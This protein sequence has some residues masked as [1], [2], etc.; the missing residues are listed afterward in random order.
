MRPRTGVRAAAVAVATALALVACGGDDGGED[1]SDREAAETTTTAVV[2]PLDILV[3]NDDGVDAEGIDVLVEALDAVDEIAVTVVAPADQR[4][5]TGDSTVEGDAAHRLA[6]TA[7]GY[8]AVAVDGYPTDAVTVALDDLGHEPDLVISGIN[9]VQN[10]GPF[11]DLSGTVAAA[12]AAAREG[13]PALAV[14]QGLAE[15]PDFDSAVVLA[16]AWLDQHRPELA[17]GDLEADVV[18]SLNVPTCPTGA[19][20]GTVE[21]TPAIEG[22]AFAEPDCTSTAEGFTEDIPA[23][24]N[25]YATWSELP[26]EP[27]ADG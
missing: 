4:S 22:D 9:D 19:P 3:T 10:L 25:G 12:R 5:G 14:S 8:D 18:H 21:V 13:I 6:A 23:F 26:L 24:M 7:S 20:R 2:E 27:S 17:T 1:R 16:L 15:E 11:V